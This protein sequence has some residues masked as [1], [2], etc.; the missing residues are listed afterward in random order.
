MFG[1]VYVQGHLDPSP[2]TLFASF[3]ALCWYCGATRTHSHQWM[4]LW[5]SSSKHFQTP[6]Q[7]QASSFLQ[8]RRQHPSHMLLCMM[9]VLQPAKCINWRATNWHAACS[10]AST[11]DVGHC[12]HDD[13]PELVHSELLPWLASLHQGEAGCEAQAVASQ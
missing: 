9:P 13:K 4:G 12:L 1:H 10:R 3:S 8:V 11:A 2:L 5:A 7:T 6:G